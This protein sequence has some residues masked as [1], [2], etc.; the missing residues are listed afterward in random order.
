[1][2]TYDALKVLGVTESPVTEEVVKTAYHKACFKFHPDRNPAGAEM[3]KL[4]NEARES[5]KVAT[6]P[7]EYKNESGYDYGDE[8]NAALNKVI[9][10]EDVKIEICGSWVW[11]SGNT[12]EHWPI[13][14]E[15]GFKFSPPKKMVYFR[16]QYAKTR[17][18]KKDGISMDEIRDKYGSDRIK[19][20]RAFYLPAHS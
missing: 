2:N 6:Y 1:M 18:F 16:P 19:G 20:K 7:I 14:K 3:M 15:A 12:K 13:F 10:L 17:H 4:V 9:H 11:V 8:I 5:L